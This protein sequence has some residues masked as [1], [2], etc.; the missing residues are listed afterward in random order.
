MKSGY[1]Q[2]SVK[3][4]DVPK[5][6]FTTRYGHYEFLMVPFGLTNAPAAFM[7]LM[8]R[9]FHPYLDQ[10]YHPGKANVVADALSR[11]S[12]SALRAM[13]AILSVASDEAIVAELRLK[14]NLLHQVKDAQKQ[15]EK[16]IIILKQI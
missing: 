16:L 9:I 8:N 12:L 11:K 13:N 4:V 7:D 5:I 6:T 15:D 3:E 14:P 1:Y 10:F 2:L